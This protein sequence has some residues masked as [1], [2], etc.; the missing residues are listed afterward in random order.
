MPPFQMAMPPPPQF[1]PVMVQP[2]ARK[3]VA[4]DLEKCDERLRKR[5]LKNRRSAERSRQKKNAALQDSQESLQQSQAENAELKQELSELKGSY[6][7]LESQNAAIK[8]LLHA[9]GIA[10]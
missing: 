6:S 8:Q 10:F 7:E 3:G 5:L 2:Q 1:Y 9:H 4:Y